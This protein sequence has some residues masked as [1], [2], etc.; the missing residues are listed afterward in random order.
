MCSLKSIESLEKSVKSVSQFIEIAFRA[1]RIERLNSMAKKIDN[2]PYS[3]V[4]RCAS[5][6]NGYDVTRLKMTNKNL[7][8]V[9]KTDGL[10]NEVA[11][12]NPRSLQKRK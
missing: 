8:G 1:Q 2:L 5:F 6:L 9:I 12:E 11:L 4:E 7:Y 3:L 10:K